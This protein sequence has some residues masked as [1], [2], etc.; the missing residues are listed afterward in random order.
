M[1]RVENEK[2]KCEGQTEENTHEG[3]VYIEVSVARRDTTI[4]KVVCY[5][6]SHSQ[7]QNLFLMIIFD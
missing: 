6:F 2:I 7:S 3:T 1:N 4:S 5:N